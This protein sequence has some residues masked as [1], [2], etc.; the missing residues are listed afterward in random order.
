[1]DQPNKVYAVALSIPYEG[2]ELDTLK[3]FRK[4]EDAQ[5]YQQSLNDGYFYGSIIEVEIT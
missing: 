4:K 1:M 2:A 3:L 5:S